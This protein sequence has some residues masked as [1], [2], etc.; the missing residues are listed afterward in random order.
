MYDTTAEEHYNDGA[1]IYAEGS[2][3]D[4]IYLIASG[5]VEVI[6]NHEG[7][8]HVI[9]TLGPGEIFGELSFFSKAP[10]LS[11]ARAKGAV[12][13]DVLDRGMLDTEFNRLSGGFQ[14]IVRRLAQRYRRISDALLRSRLRRQTPRYR[15]VLSIS[16]KTAAGLV[17]AFS[18]NVNTDGMFIRSKQVMPKGETFLLKLQMPDVPEPLQIGCEVAWSRAADGADAENPAGMG[19][20]FIQIGEHDIAQ[21]KAVIKGT[22]TL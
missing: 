11:T 21:L 19:V 13:L 2:H 4:W 8:E 10:R 5:H 1:V 7:K 6:R 17:S 9:E 20:R 18:D 16:F 22:E 14:A 12:V 3:G 15:K